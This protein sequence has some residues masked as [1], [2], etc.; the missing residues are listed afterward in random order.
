MRE[1]VGSRRTRYRLYV[2]LTVNREL[3]TGL[4]AIGMFF[5]VVGF[6]LSTLPSFRS[7]VV[8]YDPVRYVFQAFITTII[9]GVTLVV[10]ITQLVLSQEL[11]SLGDQRERMSGSV[12]FRGDVEDVFD[13]A[14]PPEPA[15]FLRALVENASNRAEAL[16][17]GVDGHPDEVLRERVD[18]L[19]DSVVSNGGWSARNWKTDSSASTRS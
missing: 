12:S 15:A 4:L 14:S 18:Q 8:E 1:R 16:R 19:V 9:S 17:E 11:G 7:Y 5:F 2:L 6:E 3:L 10:T 13:A